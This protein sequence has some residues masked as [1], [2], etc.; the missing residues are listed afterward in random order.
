MV[1]G[2][3]VLVVLLA[4]AAT[5]TPDSRGYGTHQQLGF[6]PCSFKEFTGVRC[7]SCGMTTS[8][9]YMMHGRVIASFQ[10]NSGG[11]LLAIVSL[12]VGPWAVLS[13]VTGKW[14]WPRPSEWLG[15]M[16]GATIMICTLID[17]CVRYLM[18]G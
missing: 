17:W 3:G 12:L 16:A 18:L 10:T 1:L 8:W 14:L 4:I 11:A 13:G 15:V 2:G 7:P 9:S 6:P 5:L